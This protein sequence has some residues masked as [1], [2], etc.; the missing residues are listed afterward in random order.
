MEG[1][2]LPGKRMT[3]K[4]KIALPHFPDGMLPVSIVL[5]VSYNRRLPHHHRL[6]RR[7]RSTPEH[8][9]LWSITTESSEGCV[10]RPSTTQTLRTT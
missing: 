4:K 2:G 1:G 3:L 7:S 9:T 5:S 8:K 6:R 10:S